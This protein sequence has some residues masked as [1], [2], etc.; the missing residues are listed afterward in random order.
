MKNLLLLSMLF[1]AAIASAAKY[2]SDYTSVAV[3]DCK[4]IASYQD[5]YVEIDYYDRECA[6]KAGYIVNVAGGN[7]RYSPDLVYQG[8]LIDLRTL[9]DLPNPMSFHDVGSN[10]VEWR[11]R[12]SKGK[13]EYVALI[14]RI[15][16]DNYDEK[17]GDFKSSSTLY[18][19]R[20]KG[21]DSCL[22]GKVERSADM[23]KRA[24][25]IADDETL[26]CIEYPIPFPEFK[27]TK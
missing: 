6:G 2:D 16:A 18:V 19:I 14:Y 20:L 3:S 21:A 10:K 13:K 17:T 25:A 22:V 1:S 9:I 23:N 12:L 26:P 5:P 11:Y 4:T 7:L 8:A 27:G 24:R 15:N